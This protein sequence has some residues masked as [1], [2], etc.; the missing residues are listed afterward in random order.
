MSFG[1]ATVACCAHVVEVPTF[2]SGLALGNMI[3]TGKKIEFGLST[4]AKGYFMDI[5]MLKRKTRVLI[6]RSEG[7]QVD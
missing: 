1:S 4:S 2:S 3:T 7:N 5:S 6:N